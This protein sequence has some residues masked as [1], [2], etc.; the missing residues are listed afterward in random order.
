VEGLWYHAALVNSGVATNTC[1]DA[2]EK[3]VDKNM[4][5]KRDALLPKFTPSGQK[6]TDVTIK[7]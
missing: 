1:A 6:H 3:E 4:G 7:G 5:L 2:K